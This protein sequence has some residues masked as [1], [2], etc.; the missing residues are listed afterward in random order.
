MFELQKRTSV[1]VYV[2]S[3]RQVRQLKRYGHVEYV[4]KRM[5]Y[6]VIYMNDDVLEDTVKQLKNL[7]FVRRI[8]RSPREQLTDLLNLDRV[9][10]AQ[11][12]RDND[13][14]EI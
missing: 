9:T 6:A 14:E 10:P 7:K 8:V 3:L 1:V 13:E 11:S 4:S 5:R 2:T 12:S